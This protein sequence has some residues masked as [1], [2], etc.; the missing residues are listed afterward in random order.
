MTEWKEYLCVRAGGYELSQSDNRLHL[1]STKCF[2]AMFAKTGRGRRHD[3]PVWRN[4]NFVG[5]HSICP[6]PDVKLLFLLLYQIFCSLF[7]CRKEAQRKS[8]QKE[9]PK[10]KAKRGLFE[11]SPLLNSRK[12]FSTVYAGDWSCTPKVTRQPVSPAAGGF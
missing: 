1:R 3:A 11:K 4:S 10:G 7:L 6:R 8:Y 9:T 5:G 2:P 12:N